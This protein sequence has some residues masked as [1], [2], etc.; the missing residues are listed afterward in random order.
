[1]KKAI[2]ISIIGFLIFASCGMSFGYDWLDSIYSYDYFYDTSGYGEQSNQY[3]VMYPV[4]TVPEIPTPP[5]MPSDWWPQLPGWPPSPPDNNPPV[6]VDDAATTTCGTPV[7]INV[8]SNDY[9]IDG[10]TLSV[11]GIIQGPSNGTATIS[12]STVVYTPDP[13]FSGTDGFIYK[14]KDGNCGSDTACVRVQVTCGPP[15]SD[16]CKQCG[17]GYGGKSEVYYIK[18][19]YNGMTAQATGE[20]SKGS[21]KKLKSN[22]TLVFGNGYWTEVHT[23]CSQPLYIGMT[24][25]VYMENGKKNSIGTATV[26]DL[27]TAPCV[28]EP[29]EPCETCEPSCGVGKHDKGDVYSIEATY[30][31]MVASAE[32]EWDKGKQ[33][34]LKS[35]TRLEFTNGSWVEVHTSCSQPLYIGMTVPVYAETNKKKPGNHIGYATITDLIISP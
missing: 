8:L 15:V 19:K 26:I 4:N 34:K 3:G 6:A 1:M 13:E 35:N 33:K 12:G 10:D 32:G 20:W 17:P 9:D 11:Y 23:S 29:P 30:N 25:P 7:N 31:G 28:P 2:F 21:Y 16:P 18:V 24:V 27:I 14:I 22:T 5:G